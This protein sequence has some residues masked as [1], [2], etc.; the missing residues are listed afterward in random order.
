MAGGQKKVIVRSFEESIVAGYLTAS[1]FVQNEAVAVM[2]PAG[3]IVSLPL[4]AVKHIAYVR[5]FN[6]ADATQPERIGRRSFLA[7]PRGEGL[8]VRLTFRDGDTLEGLA[9]TGL[10][11]IDGLLQDHGL[12]LALPEARSNTQR[13][14]VPRPALSAIEFL[15]A[16]STAARKQQPG[17]SSHQA[18]PGLF[19]NP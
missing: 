14:F 10:G 6:L 9:D 12:F 7:R 4:T 5:D 13:L 1:G 8:W 18:Q 3:R 16:V 19:E 2:D 17:R 15:G 11:F